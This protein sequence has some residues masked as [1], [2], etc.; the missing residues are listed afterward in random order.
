MGC[1]LFDTG[2]DSQMIEDSLAGKESILDP[3]ILEECKLL[4]EEAKEEVEE[5]GK[6]IEKIIPPYA[7]SI[8]DQPGVEIRVLLET[9]PPEVKISEVIEKLSNFH[10]KDFLLIEE[11]GNLKDIV[12]KGETILKVDE[13]NA[14]SK[15]A[16]PTMENWM[17]MLEGKAPLDENGKKIEIHHLQGKTEHLISMKMEEHRGKGLTKLFHNASRLSKEERK[18]FNEQRPKYY[19]QKAERYLGIYAEIL[20]QFEIKDGKIVKN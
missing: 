13:I 10:P 18:V 11:K 17:R 14:L 5:I 1:N 9:L 8:L 3:K 20:R 19:H 2:K 15:T 7:A 4:V 12:S 16:P 6:K